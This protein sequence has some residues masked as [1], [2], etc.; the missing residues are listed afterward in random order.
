MVKD[1]DGGRRSADTFR[2][3]YPR[4]DL[5]ETRVV[6]HDTVTTAGAGYAHLD[7]ALA[8]VSAVSPALGA[9]VSAYL[10]AGRRDAQVQLRLT[11]AAHLLA[12]TDRSTAT[13]AESV[14]YHS[15]DALR[16]LLRKRRGQSLS[17]ARGRT[18]ANP[19]R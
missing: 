4:V 10:V 19:P 6:V 13:V 9:L 16:A 7:L 3:R 17:Q 18:R 1:V 15:A 5:D 2:Q 14:G 8:L 12:T 11:Q